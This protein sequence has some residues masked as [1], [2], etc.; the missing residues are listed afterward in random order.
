MIIDTCKNLLSIFNTPKSSSGSC[1]D[2]TIVLCSRYSNT[3]TSDPI[4]AIR[5]GLASFF[6]FL[7]TQRPIGTCA[8]PHTAKNTI[9]KCEVI[10]S[11]PDSVLNS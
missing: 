6:L 5:Y 11:E 3:T 8:M 7:Y 10:N 4:T 2:G 9:S 1:I